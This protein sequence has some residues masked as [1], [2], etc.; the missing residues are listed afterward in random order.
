MMATN[1]SSARP[2]TLR[3]GTIGFSERGAAWRPPIAVTCPTN[4]AAGIFAAGFRCLPLR[5]RVVRAAAGS[6]SLGAA[7][8]TCSVIDLDVTGVE[9][10][11]PRIVLVHQG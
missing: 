5:G 6:G 3:G 8:T 7:V 2:A 9:N 4:T 10:E 11:P 1:V